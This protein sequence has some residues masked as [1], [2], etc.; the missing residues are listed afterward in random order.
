MTWTTEI[1]LIDF[2]CLVIAV[3]G[4]IIGFTLIIIEQRKTRKFL[5]EPLRERESEEEE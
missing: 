5:N 2:I 4:V 1:S 3:G